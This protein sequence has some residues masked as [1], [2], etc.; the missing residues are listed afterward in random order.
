MNAIFCSPIA[1]L[2]CTV[3]LGSP[4]SRDRSD[5]STAPPH[6]DEEEALAREEEENLLAWIILAE[7][8]PLV[9]RLEGAAWAAASATRLEQSVACMTTVVDVFEG[10]GVL[11][12]SK[13]VLQSL[14]AGWIAPSAGLHFLAR[15]RKDRPPPLVFFAF[16]SLS[17]FQFPRLV[18]S[19]RV[20]RR[21]SRREQ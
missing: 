6:D 19:E 18:C 16:F 21:V 8:T 10:G 13:H 2:V 11:C 4:G 12:C 5:R 3:R 1:T 20:G 14:C 15:I 17:L 9:R 7:L